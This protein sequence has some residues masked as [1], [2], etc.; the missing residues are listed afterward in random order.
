VSVIDYQTHK[1]NVMKKIILSLL[2]LVPGL[3][4]SAQGYGD[5][6][7]KFRQQEENKKMVAQFYQELFGDKDITAIDQYIGNT[8]IQ[9]N[10]LLPDGKEA[11]KEAVKV[12]FKGAPKEKVDIQRMAADGD[13][14]WLHIRGKAGDK[15]RAI[16][17]IFRIENGKIVEHW[18]VIQ[19]VPEKSANPHPMF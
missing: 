11:L 10:P 13:L 8:Y 14:V 6:E 18:D 3:L 16:V 12:W 17:D 19:E 9:H 2:F 1:S 5:F 15:V 4:L 7:R